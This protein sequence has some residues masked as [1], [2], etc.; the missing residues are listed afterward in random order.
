MHSF[1]RALYTTNKTNNLTNSITC[2]SLREMASTSIEKE[3]T[4]LIQFIRAIVPFGYKLYLCASEVDR[5]Q[6]GA[7]S[8][9][10][11]AFNV[12]CQFIRFLLLLKQKEPYLFFRSLR[13]IEFSNC[14][15]RH[16]TTFV[17]HVCCCSRFMLI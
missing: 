3:Y 7:R 11:L 4:C 16:S 8:F 2:S 13:K 14:N 1:E 9:S 6:F 10:R 12:R 17:P 5:I 15:F